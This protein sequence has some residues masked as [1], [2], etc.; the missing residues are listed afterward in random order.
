MNHPM[1]SYWN[2]A[3]VNFRVQENCFFVP[4][5]KDPILSP[6]FQQTGGDHFNRIQALEE[7][8]EE[9]S[10]YT[11]RNNFY[12]ASFTTRPSKKRDEFLV[13]SLSE[14]SKRAAYWS[15]LDDG[16]KKD[17][18]FLKGLMTFLP[19]L[20]AEFKVGYILEN[21]IPIS[22]V[23]IG[24]TKG[25]AVLLSGVVHQNYRNQKYSR[26]LHELVNNV[27]HEGGSKQCFFWTH[28]KKIINYADQ[29][30]R[31]LVYTKNKEK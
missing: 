2:Q 7:P 11:V 22:C 14:A 17:V 15:L 18:D 28:S 8:V 20:S 23:T 3:Y 25:E 29:V 19:D 13:E 21:D 12:L 30:H 6:R 16:F 24:T 4:Q 27:A 31:Y 26:K 5:M 10:G 1:I 9:F